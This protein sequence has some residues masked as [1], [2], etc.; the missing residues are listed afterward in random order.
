MKSAPAW[1]YASRWSGSAKRSSR[2]VIDVLR[3]SQP[4]LTDIA[5]LLISFL[6]FDRFHC[7]L[8]AISAS[9]RIETMEA[10]TALSVAASVIQFVDFGSRLLSNSR[11]LY[12]SAGGGLSENIDVELITNDVI[13]LIQ[14]LRRK[15]PENRPLS[16]P[17]SGDRVPSTGSK[18]DDDTIDHL[19]KRCVEIAEELL[20]RLE[21]LKI[22]T[23]KTERPQQAR[24][25]S[26]GH[27]NLSRNDNFQGQARLPITRGNPASIR[28]KVSN[29]LYDSGERHESLR[30]RSWRSFRKALEAAWSKNEIEKLVITLKDFRSEI[31]FRMLVM[32]RSEVPSI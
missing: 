9:R 5:H 12:K 2:D 26:Q 24:T 28:N 18:D 19:C 3:R 16:K 27:D 25:A 21:K 1:R 6:D 23:G 15:L 10:L 29:I 11:K 31:E 13:T 32:F 14:S 7:E 22:K 30:F 20:R 17:S 4:Q 8:T